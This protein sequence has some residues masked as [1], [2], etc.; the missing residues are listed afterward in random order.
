MWE[1][2]SYGPRDFLMFAP[3]TYWRL[4]EIYNGDLWPWHVAVAVAG[5]ALVWHVARH[6]PAAHRVA[7]AALALAWLWVAWGWQWQR[8]ATINWGARSL[9]AASALQAILLLAAALREPVARAGGGHPP[10]GILLALAA[11]IAYPLATAAAGASW[12]RAELAG[13]LPEPTAL[14]T[15]GLIVAVKPRQ[16]AWLGVVPLLTLMLGAATAWLMLTR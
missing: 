1:W 12:A 10:T 6:G 5:A 2:R 7:F 14:A 11:T 13:L 8:Y 15:L 16:R 9:A 4:I 3:R